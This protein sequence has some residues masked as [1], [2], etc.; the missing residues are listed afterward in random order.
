MALLSLKEISIAFGGPLLLN[1]A[2]FQIEK[3][4]RVCLVGRN[5]AGK[6]TLMKIINGKIDPDGGEV[7]KAAGLK[8]AYLSQDVPLD[9]SGTIFDV[10]ADGVG[11][12]GKLL[13]DYHGILQEIENDASEKNME[14]LEKIQHRL[15]TSDGW[16]ID[17]KVNEILSR[18]ELNPEIKFETLSV[19]MKRRVLLAKGLVCDPDILLLDEPTNHL[20]IESII[21]LENFLERYKGTLFFVTHDRKFLRKLSTRIVDL[22][23]GKLNSF[24]C[25]YDQYQE[26]KQALLDAEEEQNALFDKRLAEEEVWIRRGIKAR[27]TRNEG[28][29]RDLKKM[30]EERG[31]RR[32]RSGNVKMQAQDAERSGK[33]V[34]KVRNVS[35]SYDSN[36]IFKNFT[37]TI[38]RN[39][40]IGIIGPNGCGKS[41]LLKVILGELPPQSGEVEAGTNLDIA[42]FDQQRLQ[43]DD[44][45]SVIDNI[46]D[47]SDTI[48]FNGRSKHIIS[49]LDDFLFPKDRL[50]SPVNSLSGG[51]KNRLMLAKLFSKSSNVL[52]LDEPTN[53]LDSETLDLLEE[54]ITDYPGTVLMVSHDREFLNNI[55]TS[56]IVFEGDGL[57][58]EYVG[59]YDDWQMQKKLQQKDAVTEKSVKKE[60]VVRKKEKP[61]KLT[62]KEKKEL[63][64]LPEKIEA[65]EFENEEIL[66]KMSDPDFFKQSGEEIAAIKGQMADLEAELEITYARW[67]ELEALAEK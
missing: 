50:N 56:T 7:V 43:L 9:I 63:E 2:N 10:V 6:S 25:N 36:N 31:E 64:V 11:E 39:D 66:E 12:A 59:G 29:V 40:R 21:W 52:V 44:S 3:G 37:T 65:L 41:T 18:M 20:D 28:R 67:E 4:E 32:E 54:L 45:S 23:R 62:F 57:L 49:Y 58:K 1:K 17:S 5:G 30:R 47:G 46:G 48:I 14:K 15:D 51:E 42:Y 61:R 24:A 19:G 26:R 55:V 35:F 38:M 22:D 16:N 13:S 34:V 27:R 33:N 60:K 8:V 53:D